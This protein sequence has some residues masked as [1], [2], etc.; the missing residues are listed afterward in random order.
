MDGSGIIYRA[1]TGAARMHFPLRENLKTIIREC[2]DELMVDQRSEVPYKYIR[3]PQ[4]EGELKA[5]LMQARIQWLMN[6][7]KHNRKEANELAKKELENFFNPEG[8]DENDPLGSL[9]EVIISSNN[10]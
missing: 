2:A 3:Y 5:D 8:L 4:E 7:L 10:C 1:V 9:D 6:G